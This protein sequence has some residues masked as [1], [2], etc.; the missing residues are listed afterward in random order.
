MKQKKVAMM[1]RRR[2]K[3]DNFSYTVLLIFVAGLIVA[4][5]SHLTAF[6]AVIGIFVV[7]VFVLSF[8]RPKSIDKLDGVAFERY[9][10][11]MLRE[12]G[13]TNVKLTETYDLGVDIIAE[14]DGIK[15]GIQ[16][17]RYSGF[18]KAEAVRQA[19]T[20]L[21]HYKCDKAMVITNSYFS[22]PAIILANSN[23]CVLIDRRFFN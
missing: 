1:R 17:K 9:V 12:Q 11:R 6:V 16:V 14:K 23:D 2:N 20:A 21:K 8:K 13:Y 10:A 18:V 5:R 19:V 7:S 22:K 15:W 4:Y 3:L